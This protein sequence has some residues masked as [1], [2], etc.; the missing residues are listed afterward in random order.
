MV[1][2]TGAASG[3]IS[4]AAAGSMFGPVGTGVG[5]A[6]GAAGGLFGKKKKKKRSA[7]DK[8][9][10]Q[11]HDQ[12]FQAF[13]G[14]GPLGD[15]YN[16]DPEQANAV[17]DMETAR[18][19]QR[20]FKENIIPEITGNFR[21]AGLQNS[22]YVGDSLSKA[23]RDVQE[24]LDALRAKYL[25]GQQSESR[26]AKRNAIDNYQNRS[27]FAYDTGTE[28]GFDIGKILGSI[29]PEMKQEL[30]NYFSKDKAT[31]GVA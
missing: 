16:Y 11:L 23:G 26:A 9:Q 18:P 30:S 27:T 24:N 21:S 25:Y 12:Q 3:A 17:F 1:D 14:E 2:Y 4:G 22:S 31:A 5:G 28:Q 10:K 13:Q 19:A 7:F 15:L 6:L 29:T 8:N 20:N